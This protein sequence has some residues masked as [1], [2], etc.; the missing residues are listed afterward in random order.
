MGV[1]HFPIFSLIFCCFA[2]MWHVCISSSSLEES[3]AGEAVQL[4]EWLS[5]MQQGP[6]F[7]LPVLPRSGRV[8]HAC[9]PCI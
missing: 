8:G 9:N 2:T 6:G 7:N 5:R 4:V 3:G 1:F